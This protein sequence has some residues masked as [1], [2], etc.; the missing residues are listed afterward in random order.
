MV[1]RSCPR[2][3]ARGAWLH[4][5]WAL[6]PDAERWWRGLVVAEYDQP[7]GGLL[8]I[9]RGSTERLFTN[10]KD[11]S[12]K[13]I[14]SVANLAEP[15]LGAVV[16]GARWESRHAGSGRIPSLRGALSTETVATVHD[17]FVP[18]SERSRL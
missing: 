13:V 14:Q 6:R 17:L 18:S 5:P 3:R 2:E 16:E 12:S 15:A 11:T 7:Y 4:A 8:D 10:I 9:L 1:S